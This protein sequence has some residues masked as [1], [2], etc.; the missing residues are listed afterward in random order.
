MKPKRIILI[1]HGESEANVS[2]ELYSN[3]PDYKI[4]LTKKG[5]DQGSEAGEELFKLIGFET[6]RFYISPLWRTRD[7]F[8]NIALS[9]KPESIKWRLDPRIR[10]QEWGHLRN[11]EETNL[12]DQQRTNFGTFYFRIPDGESCADVYDRISDFLNTLYRD[13]EKSDFK[14]NAVINTNGTAIRLFLMRFFHWTPEEFEMTANPHN[15]EMFILEAYNY[16]QTSKY[17]LLTP[18]RSREIPDDYKYNWT[19]PNLS[20]YRIL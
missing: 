8:Q 20:E 12:I 6:C 16:R 3:T 13:F 19:N 4:R 15:C 7:T 9:L 2:R 11:P 5:I 14:S 17:K 18:L 1:R 10:E